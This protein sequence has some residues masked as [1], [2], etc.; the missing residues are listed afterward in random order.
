MNLAPFKLILK[1]FLPRLSLHFFAW[2][3]APFTLILLLGLLMH[4]LS[5]YE[6]PYYE[7][8]IRR[9]VGYPLSR[10]ESV[11]TALYPHPWEQNCEANDV[12]RDSKVVTGHGGGHV[13]ANLV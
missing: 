2:Y 8:P 9:A 6:C 12:K 10:S 7:C 5:Y 4:V 13:T 3:I 1:R 11:A